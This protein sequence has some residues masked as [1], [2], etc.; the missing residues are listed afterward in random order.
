MLAGCRQSSSVAEVSIEQIMGDTSVV[1]VM[2]FRVQKRCAACNA[3]GDV[4]QRTV[5]TIFGDNNN[6]RYFE[7]D[8][9]VRANRPLIE[10][11]E[12]YWNALIIAKGETFV[13]ITQRA[14]LNALSN[15]QLVENLIKQEIN[16]LLSKS[17]INP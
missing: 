3:V 1:N 12:V 6:V 2:Y 16:T 14:F 8:N 15:P 4:A 9:T 13:D 5:E 10:K 7:I 11:Y 17:Q